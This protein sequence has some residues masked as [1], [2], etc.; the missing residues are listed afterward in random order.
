MV[1][2]VGKEQEKTQKIYPGEGAD[3]LLGR[4]QGK[5]KERRRVG[6]ERKAKRGDQDLCAGRYCVFPDVKHFV[7]LTTKP[8]LG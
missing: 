5:R 6:L 3:S 2:N 1:L 8:L 7:L 4:R